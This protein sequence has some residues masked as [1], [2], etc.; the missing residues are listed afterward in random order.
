M[1]N[2]EHVNA[3]KAKVGIWT[4]WAKVICEDCHTKNV[5]A[6]RQDAIEQDD[7]TNASRPIELREGNAITFCDDCGDPIQVRKDVAYEHNLV[8]VLQERGI[9]ATMDQTGGMCSA[10]GVAL[11]EAAKNDPS[12]K[13]P[14]DMPDYM[15]ITYDD[16]GDG[17]YWMGT[18]TEFTET[19]DVP[20]AN[21]CFGSVDEVIQW[22]DEN[23]E[24]IAKREAPEKASQSDRA[25]PSAERISAEGQPSP[26]GDLKQEAKDRAAEKNVGRT[27]ANKDRQPPGWER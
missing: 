20:W 13:D 21:R 3:E 12:I 27:E 5:E 18:Y 24:K 26:L 11:S 22:M 15:L 7:R 2:N 1:S 9:E 17:L 25:I 23:Q 10:C 19:A 4:P 6:K 16:M 8:Q 14:R